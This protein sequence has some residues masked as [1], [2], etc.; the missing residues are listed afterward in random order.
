M[1]NK[2]NLKPPAEFIRACILDPR[3]PRLVE[4]IEEFLLNQS[5]IGLKDN[6]MRKGKG[7]KGKLIGNVEKL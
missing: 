7:K 4:E 5:K 1:S 6:H 3:F 2:D